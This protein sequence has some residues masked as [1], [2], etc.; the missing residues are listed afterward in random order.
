MDARGICVCVC[1][2]GI[3]PG[4]SLHSTTLRVSHRPDSLVQSAT[5]PPGSMELIASDAKGLRSQDPMTV[6]TVSWT[7]QAVRVCDNVQAVNEDD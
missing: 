7:S 4:S 6:S 1:V 5:L 2:G 3:L